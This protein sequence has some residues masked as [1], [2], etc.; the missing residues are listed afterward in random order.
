MIR[1]PTCRLTSFGALTL[2]TIGCFVPTNTSSYLGVRERTRMSPTATY[3]DTNA[4]VV[5]SFG[6]AWVWRYVDT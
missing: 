2:R 5:E 6:I 3:L 4:Y 1:G